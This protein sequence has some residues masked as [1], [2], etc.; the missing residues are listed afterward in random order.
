MEDKQ[1]PRK[2]SQIERVGN[3]CVKKYNVGSI[4]QFK[5]EV[6]ILTM[7][8]KRLILLD[9]FLLTCRMKFYVNGDLFNL[10]RK[11]NQLRDD[12][13]EKESENKTYKA[14]TNIFTINK[15][16]RATIC[17]KIIE[18]V[19]K[20]HLCGINH[21]D[22]KLENVFINDDFEFLLG[23]FEFV[24]VLSEKEINN[25]RGT[26]NSRAPEL[27]NGTFTIEDT[28]TDIYS[29]GCLLFTIMSGY[30]LYTEAQIVKGQKSLFEVF[31]E[32]EN[33]FWQM[34][35]THYMLKTK[36]S[37]NEATEL[38]NFIRLMV[39][40]NPEKRASIEEIQ[41]S[42]WVKSVEQLDKEEYLEVVNY[43]NDIVTRLD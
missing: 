18:L 43:M 24:N 5:N 30:Q 25:G 3:M 8:N 31:K 22:I 2:P 12:E 23:D 17:V 21:G 35:E 28:K 11:I 27:I 20:I 32:N 40:V 41:N 38:M 19:R 29:L 36:S 4:K 16:L 14:N 7:L 15:K 6:K 1:L 34:H 13:L 9:E 10:L 42:Q 33:K 37:S 39:N 26:E